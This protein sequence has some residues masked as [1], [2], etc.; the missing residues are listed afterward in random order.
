MENDKI[1]ISSKPLAVERN[2]PKF[3]PLG[4]YLVYIEYF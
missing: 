4:K 3:G 2:G 1:A